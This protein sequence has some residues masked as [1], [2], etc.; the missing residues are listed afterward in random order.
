LA[1]DEPSLG[2]RGLFGA[3]A[4]HV[5]V[6]DQ[7]I[8]SPERWLDGLTYLALFRP[9]LPEFGWNLNVRLALKHVAKLS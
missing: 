8:Y 4:R 1:H 6:V 2:S 7:P 3:E 9:V 5:L